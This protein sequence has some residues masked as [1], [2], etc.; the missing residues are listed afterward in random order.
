V[1]YSKKNKAQL[2]EEI[3][4][5]QGKVAELERALVQRQRMEGE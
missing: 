4:A 3:E 2:I 5:L 1:D